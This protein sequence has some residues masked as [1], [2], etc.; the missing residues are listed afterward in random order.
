MRVHSGQTPLDGATQTLPRLYQ[1]PQLDYHDITTGSNGGFN[2]GPGYDE[3]TGLGTPIAD[4]LVLDLAGVPRPLTYNAPST[5]TNNDLVLRRTVSTSTLLTMEL[6]SLPNQ[7][8]AP[9][10]LRL[11]AARGW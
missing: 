6:W 7:W 3:V 11:T 10:P 1:L 2:A 8:T 9:R 4:R 5:G